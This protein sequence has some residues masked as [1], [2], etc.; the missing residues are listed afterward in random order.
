MQL[1][2]VAAK[3]NVTVQQASNYVQGEV[4]DPI[5]RSNLGIWLRNEI[6]RKK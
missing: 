1:K 4:Q 2:E 5:I 3:F 6:A